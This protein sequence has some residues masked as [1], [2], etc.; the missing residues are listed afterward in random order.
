MCPKGVDNFR[1]ERGLVEALIPPPFA[2]QSGSRGVQ[3]WMCG[4][5]PASG[6]SRTIRSHVL[7]IAACPCHRSTELRTPQSLQ[8]SR[9]GSAF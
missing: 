9:G 4:S 8:D 7:G 2:E 5:K 3:D 1:N 6:T